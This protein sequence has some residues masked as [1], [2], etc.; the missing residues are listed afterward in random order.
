MT[1]IV[2]IDN[3]LVPTVRFRPI[4]YMPD[5]DIRRMKAKKRFGD[6]NL[7]CFHLFTALI[8]SPTHDGVSANLTAVGEILDSK[9][10][11]HQEKR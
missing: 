3:S 4:E 11:Q 10:R 9:R 7:I 6:A 8:R 5:F 2:G 1:G